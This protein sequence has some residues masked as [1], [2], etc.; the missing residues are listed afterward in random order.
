MSMLEYNEIVPK[1]IIIH[2]GEPHEV[3]ESHVA[4][5]QMRKPQNQTKLRSLLTGKVIS[6]AFHAADKVEEADIETKEIKYLYQNRGEAWFCEA[7]NPS[8]RFVLS[9]TIL[10]GKE[11]FLKPN[12]IVEAIVF[13]EETIIGIRTP[14]KVDLVVKEAAPAVKGNTVQGGSKQVVLET[15]ATLNVPMF[16]NEGDTIRINTET[17][18]YVE[19]VDKK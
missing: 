18:D 10:A 4:R 5:T 19:R 8:Q 13:D 14:I 9:A 6:V 2:Q 11:R 7:N 3:V 15:G 16:I 1:K 12:S 17:G